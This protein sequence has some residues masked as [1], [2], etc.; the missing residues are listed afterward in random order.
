MTDAS[1]AARNHEKIPRGIQAHRRKTNPAIVGLN[2]RSLLGPLL[3]CRNH[4]DDGK[5]HNEGGQHRTALVAAFNRNHLTVKFAIL[6]NLI[7][8]VGR[9][10]RI[11]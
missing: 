11:E 2:S 5:D 7:E 10:I 8:R 4:P 3:L 9:F 1:R 6:A